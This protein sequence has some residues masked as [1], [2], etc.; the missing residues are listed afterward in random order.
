MRPLAVCFALIALVLAGSCLPSK[1]VR[2]HEDTKQVVD[3][4]TGEPIAGATVQVRI[5]DVTTRERLETLARTT[6]GRGFFHVEKDTDT[7]YVMPASGKRSFNRQQSYW[8]TAE[9][10][11]PLY[12]APWTKV[13]ERITKDTQALRMLPESRASGL[14]EPGIVAALFGDYLLRTESGL[15]VGILGLRDYFAFRDTA[16]DYDCR[17]RARDLLVGKRVS[18][19]P[20]GEIGGYFVEWP[21]AIMAH[22]SLADGTDAGG[23]LLSRGLSIVDD[24][25][26]HDLSAE[27]DKIEDEAFRKGLCYWANVP[28]AGTEKP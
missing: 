28:G 24:R 12:Y 1:Y 19:K 20:D 26:D 5:Y 25:F 2:L 16:E 9:G 10:Y 17:S 15:L 13:L 23:L 18:F 14:K 22:V 8:V 27:Y 4:L 6:D 7:G 3:A 11:L 21:D